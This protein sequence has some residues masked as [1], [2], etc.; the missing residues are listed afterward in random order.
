MAHSLRK[1]RRAVIDKSPA[2]QPSW[3]TGSVFSDLLALSPSNALAHHGSCR[4]QARRLFRPF[5]SM[6]IYRSPIIN[7]YL[8]QFISQKRRQT[9]ALFSPVFAGRVLDSYQ[10]GAASVFILISQTTP[11]DDRTSVPH[12]FELTLPKTRFPG[13]GKR[14]RPMWAASYHDR[15]AASVP[16]PGLSQWRSRTR[17]LQ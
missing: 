5:A 16:Q 15:N 6:F 10:Q 8:R 17:A 9:L 12:H 13:I 7:F 11:P 2:G 14:K 4:F 3:R 1:P